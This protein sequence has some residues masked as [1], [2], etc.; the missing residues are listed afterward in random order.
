M[1]HAVD[2]IRL[3]GHTPH[4]CRAFVVRIADTVHQHGSLTAHE[5]GEPLGRDRPLYFQEL[6]EAVAFYRVR[7]VVWIRR[8]AGAFLRR[9]RERAES[10]ELR[11]LEELEQRP[12][13]LVALAG[14]AHEARRADRQVGNRVPQPTKLL[15]Q[16]MLP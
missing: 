4:V 10:V 14:K 13:V 11:L 5:A 8:G 12:E 7:N 1:R 2:V 9:V 15:P 6:L 16:R 3:P